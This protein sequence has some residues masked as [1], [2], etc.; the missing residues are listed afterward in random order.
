MACLG[1]VQETDNQLY[2]AAESYRS[3]LQLVGEPPWPTACEAFLGLARIAYQWNDLD[4][5]QAYGEQSMRLARQLENVDTPA[6]AGLFLARLK[7][8]QGEL[9]GALALLEETGEFVQRHGFS[10]WDG[11]VAAGLAALLLRQGEVTSAAE[12]ARMHDLPLI[13]V[14]VHLAERKPAAAL[15]LLKPMRQ[16]AETKGWID[17]Q[18]QVLV[19]QAAA[20][21]EQGETE[22]GVQVVAKALL[23]AE[24]GRPIRLFIDEGPPLALLLNEAA[25]RGVAPAYV[26]QLR[27]AIGALPEQRTAEQPPAAQQLSEPLTV[28]EL[29]VLRLLATDLSGPEIARELMIS[30]N[31][32]RTH[33]KNIYAKLGANSRRTALSRAD[34]LEL[35]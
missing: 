30:L 2:Q 1:Q 14:R 10:H 16:E 27:A 5:A 35:L 24:P 17:K 25:R 7:I 12:L 32:M 8:A 6:A 19:L 33:T 18:L 13:Q 31:T 22:K 21:Q 34:E 15:A 23:L 29:E 9:D 3:I 4:A 26:R 28:R 20:Y 11:A